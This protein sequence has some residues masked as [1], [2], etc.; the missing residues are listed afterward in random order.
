MPGHWRYPRLA[1][2]LLKSCC[3]PALSSGGGN[4]T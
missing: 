1:R 4:E 2:S 3:K